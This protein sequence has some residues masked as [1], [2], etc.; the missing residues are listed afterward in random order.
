[1]QFA[2]E[3]CEEDLARI[4]SARSARG[5][6]FLLVFRPVVDFVAFAFTG[7]AGAAAARAIALVKRDFLRAALFGWMTP[8]EAA[9]SKAPS[10]I[11]V[12]CASEAPT[13]FLKR[14]FNRVLASRLR[15]VRVSDWRI[16]FSAA[17]IFGT[18]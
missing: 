1:M 5:G 17:L 8:L 9:L 14:V 12:V 15:S 7:L 10:T 6:Y 2:P 18:A 16:H 3:G 11:A 13:A 4:R